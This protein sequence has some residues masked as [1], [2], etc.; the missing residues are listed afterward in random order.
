MTRNGDF[1]TKASASVDWKRRPWPA[2]VRGLCLFALLGP[3]LGSVLLLLLLVATE[4]VQGKGSSVAEL[5]P[6]GWLFLVFSYLF[7]VVPAAITGLVAGLLRQAGRL[8][9][10]RD[11]IG[12]ALLA[13]LIA[14]VWG[15]LQQFG[16]AGFGPAFLMLGLPG[17]ACGLCCALLFRAKPAP[18]AART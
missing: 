8:R 9:R 14:T 4:S 7:G 5:V 12:L 16:G 3:P 13:S 1:R 6:G 17:F 15:V 18:R 11:C 10:V 2:P